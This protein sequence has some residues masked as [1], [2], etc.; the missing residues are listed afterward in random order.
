MTLNEAVSILNE[1][2]HRGHANWYVAHSSEDIA[3]RGE[4]QY[5]VFS[6]FEAIAIAEKYVAIFRT[7]SHG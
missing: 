6:E 1:H 4:D 3:V 7:C 5:E 2:R